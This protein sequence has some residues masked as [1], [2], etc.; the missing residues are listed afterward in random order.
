[1]YTCKISFFI[2]DVIHEVIYAKV[3]VWMF[4]LI[5]PQKYRNMG[6]IYKL[7][8]SV[9]CHNHPQPLLLVQYG[10]DIVSHAAV[11]RQQSSVELL[12][13][14]KNWPGQTSHHHKRQKLPGTIVTTFMIS[15]ASLNT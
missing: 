12:Q 14:K 1:M 13:F 10:H 8:Q 5:A 9:N 15:Q 6:H 2:N 4:F 11:Q 7:Q 3:Y